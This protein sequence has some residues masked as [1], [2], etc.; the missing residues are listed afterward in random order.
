MYTLI[1]SVMSHGLLLTSYVHTYY[2][3]QYR[4]LLVDI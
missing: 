1:Y 4:T 3:I 2:V